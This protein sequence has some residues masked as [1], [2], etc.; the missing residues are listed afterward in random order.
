[1]HLPVSTHG[2]VMLIGGA[3]GSAGGVGDGGGMG[4]GGENGGKGGGWEE[5]VGPL[6]ARMEP[7]EEAR[8]TDLRNPSSHC[9]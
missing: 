6:V 1:M 2:P 7:V 5:K 4:D 3:G 9:P 8:D